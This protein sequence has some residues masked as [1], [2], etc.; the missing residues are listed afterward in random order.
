MT[1]DSRNTLHAYFSSPSK[2]QKVDEERVASVMT[3]E[4]DV[5]IPVLPSTE[6]DWG[7]EEQ[8]GPSCNKKEERYSFLLDVRDAK[9]VRKGD[10]GYDG[11]S[12]FIPEETYR[13]FTEF[14]RQFWDIKKVHYDTVIFFKKGKFYELYEEDAEI[15]AKLFDFKVVDRV[16]MKMSGFPEKSYDYW[17]GKFLE[18]GYKI[19]RVDQVENMIAKTIREREKSGKKDKIIKRELKEIITRGTIYNNDHLK[20]AISIYLGVVEFGEC[21]DSDCRCAMHGSILLYEASINK[22]FFESFCDSEDL[23]ALKTI[24]AQ[25]EIKEVITSH[26]IKFC[27]YVQVIRPLDGGSCIDFRDKFSNYREYKCFV[28]LVNYMETLK[29]GFFVQSVEIVPLKQGFEKNFSLDRTTLKN[30]DVFTNNYDS[31]TKS[32]LFSHINYCVTPF[33][34][35]MLKS[36]LLNPLKSLDEIRKRQD[37]TKVLEKVNFNSLRE[38]LSGIGDLERILG[39]CNSANPSIKDL[40][41][42]VKNLKLSA[43]L[44]ES[45]NLL[46][47]S[48]SENMR[49]SG[50]EKGAE[51][52]LCDIRGCSLIKEIIDSF[53]DINGILSEFDSRFYC[54]ENE[55]MPQEGTN[56]ELFALIEKQQMVY[57]KIKVYVDS[58]K[59]ILKCNIVLKDLGKEIFQMEIKNDVQVPKD[60]LV[61]S[62]TNSVKRFYTKDLKSLIN[63]Y[64]EYEEL[65]FQSRES[66]LRHAIE[67]LMHYKKNFHILSNLLSQIDVFFSFA[68]FSRNNDAMF[69]D[70]GSKLVAEGIRSP[71]FPHFVE[72]DVKL[73]ESSVLLLTGP[74]MGGKSTLLR[75]LCYNVILCHIGMKVLAKRFVTK[76][77]DGIFTRI[78]ASDSLEK[79]ESTFMVELSE[80]AMILDKS[81]QDSLVIVDELGR[82]TSVRDGEAIAR[83]VLEYFRDRGCTVFFSTHYHR[84]V[85]KVLGVYKGYM[86]YEISGEDVIFLYKLVEGISK[87]SHG[88][89]VAKLA[90][91]PAKI[92]ER[93]K[94]I[95]KEIVYE[96]NF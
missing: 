45:L 81:T 59:E 91:V 37:I 76:V 79:G 96:D 32:T 47:L 63:E 56:D 67:F 60:Y 2:R 3:T 25:N 35:R 34:Q 95:R 13:R 28:Y 92:L 17:S 50:R 71:V 57:R 41:G 27:S 15:S 7:A 43:D 33:G 66:L 80:T 6:G 68:M 69:P 93:A 62:S 26:R 23:V 94:Q 65:V 86:D 85:D 30:M 9:G 51:D 77:F 31:G 87:E 61:V 19:A 22:V 83:A 82:G 46:L 4:D 49:S 73:I 10:E 70:F 14:E 18:K 44:G 24:F 42:L 84:M 36:W 1:Q 38:K 74:N 53:P 21:F 16:N 52:G 48:F 75:S 88:I 5:G 72:S 89:S 55:I 54:S 40:V 11:A 8:R 90:S 12:L 78:G 39:K 64:V 29:R 20:S 58:Q